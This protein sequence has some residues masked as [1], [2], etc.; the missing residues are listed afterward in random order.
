[1]RK[2]NFDQS[3]TGVNIEAVCFYDCGMSR[4]HFEENF[5]IIQH[6]G[7][8]TSTVAYYIDNGNVE[9]HDSITFSIK[10]TKK[11]KVNYLAKEL[12]FTKTEIRTWD[13][14]TL[15]SEI[16]GQY[17]ERLTLLN[18]EDMTSYMFKD[19]KLEVIPSKKLEHIVSRGYSQG[20]YAKVFY[21]PDDLEKAWGNKPKENDIQTIIDH[22]FWDA[23][24]Y[25]SIEINGKEYSY[26]DMPE[27]SEYE[28]E[29]EKFLAYV[30]KESG[31]P[32][33]QL[34]SFIPENPDYQG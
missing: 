15:D 4:M 34:E 27:Y 22:L 19:W 3:S 14:D 17:G 25:A 10:G 33:D 9:D 26:Y 21:C 23:P 16:I 8:R 28:W 31:L 13:K 7:Y 6:S 5:A 11:E 30:S 24:I 20:D 32:V 1:M 12:T 29:R 2:N 18:Y